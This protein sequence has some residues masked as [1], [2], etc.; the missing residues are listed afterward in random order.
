MTVQT[1]HRTLTHILYQPTLWSRQV[2]NLLYISHFD[3]DIKHI[4]G[5]K[6]MKL[7]A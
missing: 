3:F 1:D 6:N 7:I 5:A 4:A 2:N